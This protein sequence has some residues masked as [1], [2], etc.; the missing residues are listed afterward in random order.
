MRKAFYFVVLVFVLISSSKL[1]A[2]PG[3]LDPNDADRIFTSTNQP[4]APAYA[5]MS[6]W[7][8]TNRLSWNPYSYGFKSYYFKG[9]AFRLKFP[10]TY[11]HNVADGKVYPMLLFLHGMV[12][13]HLFMIMSSNYYMVANCMHKP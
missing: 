9:M 1:S 13:L 5:I 11:Q 8:H 3:V 6:K 4:P 10:K 7:G 2:Q 12:N